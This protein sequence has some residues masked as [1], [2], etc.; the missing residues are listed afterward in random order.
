MDTLGKTII[1]RFTAG[2]VLKICTYSN[3]HWQITFMELFTL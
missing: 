3:T 1:R 2:I